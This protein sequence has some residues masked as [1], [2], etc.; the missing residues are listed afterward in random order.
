MADAFT[1]PADDIAALRALHD[2]YADAV[3]RVDAEAWGALWAADAHW[4]LM[5]M[6]VD[7]REAIVALW[8]GAMAGFEFVGFFSQPGALHAAGDS[9]EG[10]VWTHELLVD[11]KGE[12]RPLGRYDDRYVKQGGRWLFAERRFTLRRG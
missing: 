8:K 4:D 5:G 9:G 12:R 10:R 2:S 1:G 11:A 7:G 6:K 3:N